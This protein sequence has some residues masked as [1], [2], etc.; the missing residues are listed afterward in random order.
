MC[1]NWEK[2]RKYKDD[3][4]K[5]TV[6]FL[7]VRRVSMLKDGTPSFSQ[8]L[9]IGCIYNLRQHVWPFIWTGVLPSDHKRE[10]IVKMHKTMIQQRDKLDQVILNSSVNDPSP[11]VTFLVIR[12]YDCSWCKNIWLQKQKKCPAKMSRM[13]GMSTIACWSKAVSKAAIHL[14]TSYPN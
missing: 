8:M 11:N 10:V 4:C 12:D 13:W 6:L 9:F 7:S 5:C 14:L 1:W 3:S 2:L